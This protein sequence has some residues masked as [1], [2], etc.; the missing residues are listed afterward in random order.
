MLL[1][2]IKIY[3]IFIGIFSHHKVKN[4]NQYIKY[5][6][7]YFISFLHTLAY[8]CIYT[9]YIYILLHTIYSSSIYYYINNTLQVLIY[10][11]LN[12]IYMLNK[13]GYLGMNTKY[14]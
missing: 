12:T 1:N 3:P 7:L 4:K 5:I 14:I 2:F 10:S 13:Y 9:E 8:L 11:G 6:L